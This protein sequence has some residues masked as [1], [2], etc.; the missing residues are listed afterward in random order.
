MA[1]G[2]GELDDVSVRKNLKVFAGG[3]PTAAAEH[4]VGS[5]FARYGHVVSCTVC[6]PKDNDK[7]APYAFV[8]YKFAADA[9]C[10]V[11]DQQLFPGGSKPLAMGFATPRRKEKEEAIK[12]LLNEADPCKIFVGGIG[13]KDS[14]EEIGD[15]FSQ[16]GLVSLV[17]RDKGG[18]GFVNFATREGAL[19]LLE[20]GNVVFQ[21]RK[22]D[23]KA[24]DSKRVM[25]ES[26]RAELIKRAVA[27]HFH[28][29]SLNVSP[30]AP[31]G[32]YPGYYPPPYYGYPPAGYPPPPGYP[33]G[34]PPPPAGYPASYPG[35]PPPPAG[36]YPPPGY[37][38]SPP[39][40]GADGR[41]GA[42]PPYDY[43]RPPGGDP[44]GYYGGSPPPEG[45]SRDRDRDRD[46][47][48]PYRPPEG[49]D[50]YSRAP[51][52]RESRHGPY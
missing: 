8:T 32:G 17:Y 35:Y 12:S 27:R 4:Q 48:D 18:W 45:K 52:P 10:A 13:E 50:P 24:S 46:P 16:W 39:P 9:D 2:R 20:E 47:R 23:I 15:F 51:D 42:P 25:D 14:E 31:P 21:R 33:A 11:V 43:Y 1:P 41:E 38:S 44:Y 30:A 26:E 28:K 34:Y 36:Y 5:H 6:L 19:R 3:L 29:K 7:K 37:Y 40:A 49:G 22:L